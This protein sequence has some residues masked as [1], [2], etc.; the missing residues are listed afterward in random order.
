MLSTHCGSLLE[1]AWLAIPSCI[2]LHNRLVSPRIQAWT[3]WVF[4][5]LHFLNLSPEEG[6]CYCSCCCHSLSGY[7]KRCF[8]YKLFR[9]ASSLWPQWQARVEVWN[10][11][12]NR[13]VAKAAS[14]PVCQ[15]GMGNSGHHLRKQ[16]VEEP[17][18]QQPS[19]P[20]PLWQDLWTRS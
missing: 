13:H 19:I 2:F 9:T 8:P 20:F 7:W 3:W 11:L 10:R 15:E 5:T 18:T 16:G 6:E 14:T 12:P 4:P 17:I 1:W